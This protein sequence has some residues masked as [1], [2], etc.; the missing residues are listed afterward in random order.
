MIAKLSLLS[1]SMH[2]KCK[3]VQ[4]YGQTQTRAVCVCVHARTPAQELMDIYKQGKQWGELLSGF[5]RGG[6]EGDRSMRKEGK[7]L[8][9]VRFETVFCKSHKNGSVN[10]GN[11]GRISSK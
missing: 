2:Y 11:P 5:L 3:S 4:A 10:N 6:E 8:L 1:L 7:G 9:S